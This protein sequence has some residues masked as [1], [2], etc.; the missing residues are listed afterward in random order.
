MR[1]TNRTFS[2][3]S[4]ATALVLAGFLIG[5]TAFADAPPPT[6]V[7]TSST[8]TGD[9]VTVT[10]ETATSTYSLFDSTEFLDPTPS[11][12]PNI[13]NGSAESSISHSALT[14]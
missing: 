4:A 5:P 13:I 14:L 6:W 2:A 7:P 11:F 10:W 12:R 8:T 9:N 3:V 1:H